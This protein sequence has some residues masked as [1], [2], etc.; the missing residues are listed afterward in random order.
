M[1]GLG[2]RGLGFRVSLNSCRGSFHMKLTRLL[3][4]VC[5]DVDRQAHAHTHTHS[6]RVIYTLAYCHLCICV[7]VYKCLWSVCV[8]MY[9]ERD[10]Y[11]YSVHI[12]IYMYEL[13]VLAISLHMLVM[14]W[15][16]LASV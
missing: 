3:K 15:L 11:I 6:Y 16:R 8:Y 4:L 1:Q 5:T 12:C 10:I 2:F 7:Y 13:F 9:I 14:S